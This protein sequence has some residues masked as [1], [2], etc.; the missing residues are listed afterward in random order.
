MTNKSDR[1]IVAIS[2]K[3]TSLK[4]SRFEAK[5]AFKISSQLAVCSTHLH[6]CFILC[7]TVSSN[8]FN[9][10]FFWIALANWDTQTPLCYSRIINKKCKGWQKNSTEKKRVFKAEFVSIKFGN[11]SK[12]IN[13]GQLSLGQYT[14]SAVW[15]FH[16]NS[17]KWVFFASDSPICLYCSL[18]S[19]LSFLQISIFKVL[20]QCQIFSNYSPRCPILWEFCSLP[21]QRALV[22]D[23]W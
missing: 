15:M 14:S 8:A 19:F 18:L 13:L 9:V 20:F 4:C 3:L 21:R 10:V 11:T 5:I 2:K 7:E 22:Q 6:C 12:W 23:H 1:E 17:R 16:T